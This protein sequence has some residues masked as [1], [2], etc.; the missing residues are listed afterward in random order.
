MMEPTGILA[1]IAVLSLVTVEFGG[2]ALLRFITTDRDRLG[3][4]RERFIRAGHAHAGVLLVLSLVY[5]LYLPRAAFPDSVEWLCGG[6]LLAGVLAQSGGFLI[7]LAIGEQGHRPP[8]TVLT[9]VGALLRDPHGPAGRLGR[10]EGPGRCDLALRAAPSMSN[11]SGDW[12]GNWG[13]VAASMVKIGK[14]SWRRSEE[15]R[16]RPGPPRAV[17]PTRPLGG[18]R[19]AGHRAGP[20][21]SGV[22]TAM[23]VSLWGL[24]T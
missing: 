4:F 7:H 2:H 15:K 16:D 10:S 8:G 14:P 3:E 13:R 5:P 18:R 23:R 19:P 22:S 6:A 9:R 20:R 24:R 12:V 1:I 17:P 11:I 21:V